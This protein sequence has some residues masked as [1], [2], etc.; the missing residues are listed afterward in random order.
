ME[1]YMIVKWKQGNDSLKLYEKTKKLF[2]EA[3]KIEGVRKTDVFISSSKLKERY[4]MMIRIRMK[5]DALKDLERSELMKKW[6]A[7]FK[8]AIEKLTVFDS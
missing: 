2:E 6:N 7:E 1:R 4:D 5:K 8:D 3:T